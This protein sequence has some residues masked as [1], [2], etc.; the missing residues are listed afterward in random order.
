MASLL[1][2]NLEYGNIF[3]CLFVFDSVFWIGILFTL[4]ELQKEGVQS[5]WYGWQVK[6]VGI[7]SGKKGMDEND[8]ADVESRGFAESMAYVIM[9]L[10]GV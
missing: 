10:G 4:S 9:R 1:C 5:H 3:F 6:S 7:R 8:L 2:Y